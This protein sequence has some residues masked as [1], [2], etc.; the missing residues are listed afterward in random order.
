M[1]NQVA[2]DSRK[3]GFLTTG[4]DVM[5]T[6]QP[7]TTPPTGELAVQVVEITEEGA[8]LMIFS[9]NDDVVSYDVMLFMEGSDFP[10]RRFV[11][12]NDDVTMVSFDALSPGKMF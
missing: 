7:E 6:S 9:S 4:D 10:N 3:L 8:R 2:M 12:R 5:T 1:E 11:R